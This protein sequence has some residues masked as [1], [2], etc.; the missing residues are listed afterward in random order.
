MIQMTK[1]EK[2]KMA[3]LFPDRIFPRTMRHDSKRGHYFCV[4]EPGLVRALEMIRQSKSAD[5]GD[6]CAEEEQDG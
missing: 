4:E 2:Q 6:N 1:S 5:P 3:K